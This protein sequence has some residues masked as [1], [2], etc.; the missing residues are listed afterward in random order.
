M[1]TAIQTFG[2]SPEQLEERRKHLGASEIPVVTGHIPFKSP[3]QLWAEKRGLV[4]PFEGNEFTEW[5][6]RLEG[7]IREKYAEVIGMPVV[8]PESSIICVREPWRSCTPDGLVME[9]GLL[10]S[11][12]AVRGLEIKCR[13]A[14]R[15][16]EWGEPGTDQ[17][18]PD[19]AIQAHWSMDITGL[20]EWDVATLIGGNKF[21]LYHL[22][23][24]GD[25]AQAL[26]EKGR[27]FWDYVESGIEPPV[28]GL[29]ATTDYLLRKFPKHGDQLRDATPE[30]TA[31]LR[32]ILTVRSNIKL[33]E[34]RETELG[35]LL[36][37]AIGESA[38][39]QAAG[40]GKVTWKAPRS[41]NVS[42]KDVAQRLAS[43]HGIEPAIVDALVAQHTAVPSRRFVPAPP[44]K[45]K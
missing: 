6:N 29:E 20:S 31:W 21:G 30:E 28:D 38:G 35:N 3:L 7:V 9:R 13:G 33:L 45:Q 41:G 25:I 17:V 40:V 10:E 24:D 22:Y 36:R 16:E 1:A 44:G 37:N 23:Y 34:E 18:P 12:R 5:G 11:S 8:K 4:V 2:F 32:D 19:V 27:A 14:F 39:L 42:W 26:L 15:D 43:D